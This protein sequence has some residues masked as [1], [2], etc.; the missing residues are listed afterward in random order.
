MSARLARVVVLIAFLFSI[1]LALP[2]CSSDDPVDPGGD[3]TPPPAPA[4][5]GAEA[6]SYTEIDVSWSDSASDETGFDLEW[7][8]VED[9]SIK[10]TA[11]P[12]A[13]AEAYLISGL[14]VA[15]RYHVRLRAV[16]AVGASDWV[17]GEATTLALPAG[18]FT[19]DADAEY[20]TSTAVTLS[21]DLD[22]V[23]WMRFA[24]EG[25]EWSDWEAY[26][27][28]RAWTLPTGDGAKT[29]AAQYRD[30][31]DE[32]HD[33]SDSIILDTTPPQMSAMFPF[34][35]N[36]YAPYTNSTSVTL[37]CG[38]Q[39][40]TRMQFRND[41]GAWS[42]W[43]DYADPTSWTLVGT[44][45]AR[46]VHAVFA[47]DA[48]NQLAVSDAIIL[49]SIPPSVG[50]F[51]IAGGA[52]TTTTLAVTLH[53]SVTEAQE[54]RFSNNG[55][56]W[57]AWVPYA[58]TRSWNL[59]GME[60]A[61]I[62]V[63]AQFKDIAGNIAQVSDTI[64]YD[65]ITRL[66]VLVDRIWVYMDGDL[67]GNGEWH[68]TAS[69]A[70][71]D[72]PD[73]WYVISTGYQSIDQGETISIDESV[74]VPL[75]NEPGRYWLFKW[76]AWEEDEPPIDPNDTVGTILETYDY[77]YESG[78][79]ELDLGNDPGGTFHWSILRLD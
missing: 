23:Q 28:T 58:S 9:F 29:V 44:Q 20:A 39:G 37:N 11:E 2:G 36:T 67:T 10:S 59:V 16:N 78:D 12:E 8:T 3:P 42:A 56:S 13:D 55:S 79:F 41:T 57:S 54:M 6:R 15:T 34:T 14:D 21:S 40:A 22:G 66:E 38:V 71:S 63:H 32:V 45:G 43:E 65:A 19:I 35:I 51:A 31:F 18:T 47:D 73:V 72:Y 49:D 50:S 33:R 7:S 26:A 60:D 25:G 74:V 27:P 62:A 61:T 46:T 70:E 53:C 69:Y 77:P 5:L 76:H 52:Q 30:Q 17:V 68:W 1:F 4:D 24:D 75:L 48:G 64:V